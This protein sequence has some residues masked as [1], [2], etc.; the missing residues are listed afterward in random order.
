MTD[1]KDQ[2]PIGKDSTVDWFGQ[3]VQRDI[4]DADAAA[5]QAPGDPERAEELFEQNRRDHLADK[6]NVPADERPS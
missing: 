2:E 5:A 6:F 1:N 4:E 3:D